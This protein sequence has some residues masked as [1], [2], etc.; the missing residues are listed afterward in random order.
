MIR[1]AVVIRDISFREE[2]CR[3][4]VTDRRIAMIPPVMIRH[5]EQTNSESV[6]GT[7]VMIDCACYALIV[8]RIYRIYE[9]YMWT[10][11]G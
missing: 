5:V 1:P 11:R 2:E 3:I 10:V 7:H 6:G 9:T 8:W 4:A